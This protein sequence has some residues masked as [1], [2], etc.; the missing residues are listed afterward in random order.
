MKNDHCFCIFS[1]SIKQLEIPDRA[2]ILHHNKVNPFKND[3]N[4]TAKNLSAVTDHPQPPGY[5]SI[6]GDP[7]QFA[8]YRKKSCQAVV[9]RHLLPL[10]VPQPHRSRLIQPTRTFYLVCSTGQ[11][12]HL[13]KVQQHDEHKV[14]FPLMLSQPSI[15]FLLGTC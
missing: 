7:C 3:C 10:P 8:C 12:E 11:S 6:P 13:G 1:P 15:I 4:K 2:F 5:P 9:S 14:M